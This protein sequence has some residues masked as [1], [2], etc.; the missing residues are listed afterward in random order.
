MKKVSRRSSVQHARHRG[1]HLSLEALEERR[2]MVFGG[3]LGQLSCEVVGEQGRSVYQAAAT[4]TRDLS[5]SGAP[6]PEVY[7]DA[8]RDALIGHYPNIADTLDRVVVHWNATLTDTDVLGGKDLGSAAGQTFG[9][10]VYLEG[11]PGTHVYDSGRSELL[12][13]ELMHVLQF[14]RY[15]SSLSNFGYH[16]FKGW[17]LAGFRYN[18]N[19]LEEEAEAFADDHHS[20]VWKNLWPN[21]TITVTGVSD[22]DVE[23]DNESQAFSWAVEGRLEAVEVTLSKDG[24]QVH[25]DDPDGFLGHREL[26]RATGAHNFD[27]SGEGIYEL[28]I[29]AITDYPTGPKTLTESYL[30][31]VKD[32]DDIRPA[33]GIS[34]PWGTILDSKPRS[35]GWNVTDASGISSNKVT[36]TGP[37]RVSNLLPVNSPV[38]SGSVDLAACGTGTFV[39]EVE[40]WDADQDWPGDDLRNDP[41]VAKR[42]VTIRDDDE[43]PPRIDFLTTTGQP[44][45]GTLYSESHGLANDVHWNV[46]DYSGV[47]QATAR[48]WRGEQLLD[49]VQVSATD[50]LNL[51]TYGLG[52]FRVELTAIDGDTDG[53]VD[54]Q[55]DNTSNA[56][57]TVTND[58]PTVFAGGPYLM[59]EGRLL[60]LRGVGSDVDP[61]DTEQL[62]Y[63]WDLDGDGQF[64]D[65]SG[66][67]PVVSWDQ[68]VAAGI[69]DDGTYTVQVQATDIF[70]A[71]ATASANVT[72]RN[73]APH[74]ESIHSQPDISENS[75]LTVTGRYSDPSPVDTH[76]VL[77]SWGDGTSSLAAVDPVARTFT[78][79]HFY[80][81]DRPSETPVD[82]YVLS[83]QLTDDDGAVNPPTSRTLSV[84]TDRTGAIELPEFYSSLPA[85]VS[86]RLQ[87]AHV[88]VDPGAVTTTE[89]VAQLLNHRH[90]IDYP[91]NGPFDPPL[92]RTTAVSVGSSHYH[93]FD[94]SPQ[95]MSFTGDELTTY[96]RQSGDVSFD[97]SPRTTVDDSAIT[98]YANDPV[99]PSE[100]DH[101]H[102]IG[103]FDGS[104]DNRVLFST[105]TTFSYLRNTVPATSVSLPSSGAGSTNG[106]WI[107]HRGDPDTAAYGSND[108]RGVHFPDSPSGCSCGSYFFYG[109]LEGHSVL[110]QERPIP[111]SMWTPIDEGRAQADLSAYMGGWGSQSDY[112]RIVLI[113]F[114][115][116]H[117]IVGST[118]LTGPSASERGNATKLLPRSTSGT[119]PSGARTVEFNLEFVRVSSGSRNDGYIDNVALS[120]TDLGPATTWTTS[121][122]YRSNYN[123]Y[124]LPKFDASLGTLTRADVTLDAAPARTSAV[125][126]SSVEHDH[127][128]SLAVPPFLFETVVTSG[129][130][131]TET[132]SHTLEFQE[133]EQDFIAEADLRQ[134]FLQPESVL[135]PQ[136]GVGS[137]D[138]LDHDH[139]IAA[140][141]VPFQTTT[142]FTYDVASLVV[143]VHNAEPGNLAV[144]LPESAHEDEV[145]SLSGSF[146]DFGSSD[147]HRVVVDWG[148]NSSDELSVPFG[149]YGF[150]ASHQYLD[151]NPSGSP[152]DPYTVSVTVYDD[153]GG[154]TSTS[155]VITLLNE[156]PQLALALPSSVNE[157]SDFQLPP[158]S[159]TDR[160]QL[161]THSATIDWGDNESSIA[162]IVQGLGGGSVQGHHVYRDEGNYTLQVALTDDDGGVAAQTIV[163]PVVN[164]APTVERLWSEGLAIEGS[165]L[166][167][168]A[169]V[170]DPGDDVLTYAWD[171]GDNSLP[172]A[173]VDLATVNHVFADEGTYAVTL[174]VDDGDGGRVTQSLTVVVADL[175]T[176]A[177]ISG[178][179]AAVEGLPYT[180]TLSAFT[181]EAAAAISNWIVD[182]GDGTSS[183]SPTDGPLTHTYLDGPAERTVRV[184]V[185]KLAGGTTTIGT[186]PVSTLNAA[187]RITSLDGDATGTEGETL[188]YVAAATDSGADTLT[189]HWDFGDGTTRSGVDLRSVTHAFADNGS[190]FVSLTVSDEDGATDVRGYPVLISNDVPTISISG[191]SRA[192]EGAP[193]ELTLGAIA[194]AG[195]DTV[196]QWVV[197]WGDGRSDTY[198]AGGA[199][200]HA[201]ADGPSSH[202]IRVTLVDEDGLHRHVA[203]H[204]VAVANDD[205]RIASLAFDTPKFEGQVVTLSSSV[206]DPAGPY[207]LL[208]YEWDFGDGTPA[209]RGINLSE[210]RHTFA[211]NGDYTVTL[212][213][214]DEDGGGATSTLAVSIGNIVPV[215][216][217]SGAP[218]AFEGL[219]YTLSFG[220]IFDPGPDTVSQW[221]VDWGDGRQ[222]VLQSPDDTQHIYADGLAS[223]QIRLSVVDEDGTHVDVARLPVTVLNLPPEL[224]EL[225]GDPQGTEG[226]LFDFHAAG[227]DVANDMLTYSWDF[228]DGTAVQS[229]LGLQDV[230]HAYADDGFYLL[231][232]TVDDGDGGTDSASLLIEVLNAVPTISLSGAAETHEGA[233]YA[234]TLGA[235]TDPGADTVSQYFVD[236]GDG[237]NDTY[238]ANGVVTHTFADGAASH[239]IRVTLADEDGL[240]A[241]ADTLTV[242]VVNVPPT[243]AAI[244]PP[245]DPVE[246]DDVSFSVAASDPAGN[247][248]TLTYSWD[249]GD[250]SAVVSAAGLSATRHVYADNGT[251]TVRVTVADEDGGQDAREF[252]LVVANVGPTIELVGLPSVDETSPYVLT[253]GTI[254]DP[255]ADTVAQWLVDWGDGHI[256][257]Y[258]TGGAVTHS[259]PDGPA[260][261]TIT[262][263][264]VDEDGTHVAG[265]RSVTVRNVSPIITANTEQAEGDESGTLSFAASATDVAGDA[266]PLTYTWDFGDGSQPVSGVELTDVSHTYSDNGDYS[267]RLTVT[268][269]DGGLTTEFIAVRVYNVAPSFDSASRDASFDVVENSIQGTLAGN[270]SAGDPGND[271]LSYAITG[272]SGATAFAIDAASGAIRV[273]DPTQLDYE[274]TSSFTL[275]LSVTDDDGASDSTS[276]IIQLLNQA[277]ITGTVF[278][279]TDRDG[280][281]AANEMGIDFVTVQL[282]DA[283]GKVVAS[284]QTGDGGFYL[285]ED[286]D[287][288]TYR[289]REVQPSG[290]ADGDEQPGSL[291][292]TI[293][294][295]DTIQL[296]LARTDA[297]D[298]IFAEL[299]QELTS[300]DTAGIGFWQNKHGQQLITAGGSALA[301]WLTSNFGNVF[302]NQLAGADGAAV[303]RFYREQVFKKRVKNP[304]GPANVDAQF[305]AVA[306]ATWFTN[307]HLAGEVAAGFGFQVSDTGIGT[308]LVNVGQRGAA[309]NTQDHADRTIMQLL[310]A[311][312]ELTDRP[313]NIA[314]FSYVY[315]SNGDGLMS[316][317]EAWLRTLANELYSWMNEA[318][319]S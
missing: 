139:D 249:F 282:L 10:H 121:P 30:F 78:A 50:R 160:G 299:G 207:D 140:G 243:I 51:D 21:P 298:Y 68:W 254:G 84:V 275:Q 81:D 122:V 72:V 304:A 75:E 179:A 267:V 204:A 280:W 190:Y 205:P 257:T 159:F 152:A 71:T 104:N 295:N 86:G 256:Q 118:T 96:F 36:I 288:G 317:D 29:K 244:S 236:W 183:S 94:I 33:P 55:L 308:R 242:N 102:E 2:L 309:F 296:T 27:A 34:G 167:L 109:G 13:H 97:M 315:D 199:V 92:A 222:D 67:N 112:S 284:G 106:S 268:D 61:G 214:T 270:V 191:L 239:T 261:P 226:S 114:N 105:T 95:S 291:G 155:R 165:G 39:L 250:G 294:G 74:I 224:I 77:V 209:V 281:Y 115:G 187:P 283:D 314:G 164:V 313:D 16:Y 80:A 66:A 292:G 253:L 89:E 231:T 219:P 135:L 132:H 175:S 273:A 120:I 318:G 297:H 162:S 28:E 134:L 195:N 15:S 47:D 201:Y 238:A 312:N 14:E 58:P 144:S 181:P 23:Y 156:L 193:F 119:I 276:V 293:V 40:A 311:T 124:A 266:D 182:W 46:T 59:E 189:Y 37:C 8:V 177:S 7:K 138:A 196:T 87:A 202:T 220:P 258:S 110:Y 178:G 286:V 141:T 26:V 185:E 158:A 53:W 302:G 49:T 98:P 169:N 128:L 272:G 248:D 285:I 22:G 168:R 100:Y 83:V 208:T 76:Q 90:S 143:R 107:T 197:D 307:R 300:G 218:N 170:T 123:A 56:Y 17:C 173:G 126:V 171:F 211:D 172:A 88:L 306:L 146:T 82:E 12:L 252:Q 287:P 157:G 42:S 116:S 166:T 91:K 108:S 234:L 99:L 235:V 35:F 277:S 216:V 303:A 129:E 316:A 215:T 174:L 5:P 136:P 279:D 24:V 44:L 289:L 265:Q 184:D 145:V 278:I 188:D 247:A 150:A 54:D 176:A 48:L 45:L 18:G 198:G 213:V 31:Q 154:S 263:S 194:D 260:I 246:G 163:V 217:L 69:A 161:D 117:Q 64:D 271:T 269:G 264:L 259:Y 142:T 245:V 9:Y 1:R 73:G 200:T 113:W 103:T 233:S 65:A 228:G 151:D 127:S 62:V 149:Q 221:I 79:T 147:T 186:L 310:L 32:D 153:D 20:A 130:R 227:R 251:Y 19:D 229:G 63:A 230:S 225:S 4:R 85:G 301:G 232:V 25:H 203:Q 290:V 274:T 6:L 319:G 192:T 57:L 262:V 240:Y 52:T 43:H 93:T 125:D 3:F 41:L 101:D 38:L 137:S 237:S 148:D 206:S 223:H 210:V 212:S 133:V 180:L 70:H 241:D 111:S 11:G 60:Q 255:G 131:A 305:M